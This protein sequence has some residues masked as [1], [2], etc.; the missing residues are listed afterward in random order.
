MDGGE[1]QPGFTCALAGLQDIAR[2]SPEVGQ[3]QSLEMGIL[4]QPVGH[5]W[6]LA[7]LYGRLPGTHRSITVFTGKDSRVKPGMHFSFLHTFPANHFAWK[8][9]R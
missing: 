4:E 6:F 5:W 9:S 8:K 3:G 1:P 7:S 2:A